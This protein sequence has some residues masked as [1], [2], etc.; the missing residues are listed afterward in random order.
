[1][2]YAKTSLR[3]EKR[4]LREKMRS[5]G[6]GYQDIAAEFARRYSL[7]PRAAWREAY[8]WSLQETADRINEFRGQ[9]G[10]DPGGFAGMTAPHLCEHENWP[11]HGP[12]PAG[13]RPTPYLLAVLAA[14]YDCAVTD[15]IDLADREH[16]PPADLLILDKYSQ[17]QASPAAPEMQGSGSPLNAG[18]SGAGAMSPVGPGAAGEPWG[19]P[20]SSSRETVVAANGRTVPP[21]LSAAA[22]SEALDVM[23][24]ITESNA[25]DDVIG[26]LART[27][28]YLAEAHARMPAV[29]I[30]SEVLGVHRAVHELLRR[31]RQRL[32]QTRDLLRIDSA[33]LAHAC[34]LLG[35]L[36][37]YQ[38]ARAYGSAALLCA[39][40]SGADEGLAWTAMAK[41]ARWQD[42]FAEAAGLAR[43]GFE[44]SGQVPVRAELAYREANAIALLGDAPGARAA[45]HGAAQA[46]E[47]LDDAG[48][49][50]WSFS[51]GR[52]AI[53]TLSVCI[54]TGDPDGALRAAGQADA[55]WNAGGGKVT[56]TWAQVRAGA[57]MAHLLKDSLDGAAGELGPVLELSPDQ[58]ISTVTG[59]L[60]E[61]GGMLHARRFA[62][63][64]L[65]S[66]LT[67]QVGEFSAPA[68]KSP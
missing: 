25:S 61:I 10:L 54:H 39:Q 14:V 46:A 58:R 29:R 34:L 36:G 38:A 6:L 24:W 64:P 21:W 66:A 35:D 62:G 56:A 48:T 63:S 12:Q 47:G 20:G 4:D 15:L 41:T 26:E 53:F 17:R 13:R 8:G 3:K 27:A 7:R 45:L 1:M 28:G 2:A 23:T 5:M 59:Y 67:E 30:L 51:L 32:S 57:A 9:V 31:G 19:P 49:S 44:V 37:Q 11:G 52:Q 68:M 55:Y 42:R 43:R 18:D 40:E 33:V 16:L 65:A 22:G 50:A 60:D